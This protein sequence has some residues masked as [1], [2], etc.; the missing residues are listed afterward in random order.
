MEE[1]SWALEMGGDQHLKI[2]NINRIDRLN[3]IK[4]LMITIHELWVCRSGSSWTKAHSSSSTPFCKN[5]RPQTEEELEETWG[6][7]RH[8][9]GDPCSQETAAAVQR[10]DSPWSYTSDPYGLYQ[11]SAENATSCWIQE[12]TAPGDQLQLLLAAAAAAARLELLLLE[13]V[14]LEEL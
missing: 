4:K 5:L 7:S 12:E 14:Q 9:G 10:S 11:V 8:T 6:H 1:N 3:C 2:M 13:E